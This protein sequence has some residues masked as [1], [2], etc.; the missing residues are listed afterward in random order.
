M[1]KIHHVKVFTVEPYKDVSSQKFD[2]EIEFGMKFKPVRYI[3]IF[4]LF[5][6]IHKIKNFNTHYI[7]FDQPFMG[8]MIPILK[9][10]TGKK[11]FIRSNNIEYLRFKSVGKI[12][13]QLMY[14]F[15]KFVY[16][17]ADL[18]IFV[19]DTDRLK[20]IEKFKLKEQK[21]MLTPYGIP[22]KTLPEPK[23]DARNWLCNQYKIN[24]KNKLL[25]FFATMSY[26]PNYDAVSFIAD[27]IYPLLKK[28]LNQFTILICGKNLPD[29]ILQKLV[30]KPEIIYCGFVDDIDTYIDG[31][32]VM[33]N[34][35]LSGGGVKTKA[36]DTLGRGAI[37]VSTQTGAEGINPKVCD[38]NLLIAKDFDWVEFTNLI[39]K[40]LFEPKPNIPNDFFDE[41]SWPGIINR[42]SEKLT[43][44]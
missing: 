13:W 33:I 3:N 26:K 30:N 39:L 14:M 43:T 6:L 24:P 18:V 9:F 19:S 15:E 36:I 10:F 16:Q 5:K 7:F 35:I 25:L 21:T 12:W 28:S 17:S 20:A 29:F 8:W 2:F 31:C 32:D 40:V 44:L 41:Y 38:N 42:L 37:V 22:H 27:E 11:V 1:G 23:T 34:P 4:L